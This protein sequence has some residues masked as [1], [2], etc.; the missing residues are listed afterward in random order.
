MD[1]PQS[2]MPNPGRTLRPRVK[3]GKRSPERDAELIA[4]ALDIQERDALAAGQLGYMART[5][6]WAS[7]PHSKVDGAYYKRENGLA[8]ITMLVDPDIGLPYGK[9][10][11]LITAWMTRQ[12]KLTSSPEL[13]LGR[14][15]NEFAQKLGLST[16]GGQRGDTSRLKAQAT[17]LLSTFISVN[18][19][20]RE[21]FAYK[22]VAVSDNGVLFWHPKKPDEPS[23]W[24]STITLS[25]AFYRDCIDCAVPFDLRVLHQLR[26]SLAID[27]YLWLTWR[28]YILHR[29]TLIPWA[30][31]RAQ[32]GAGYAATS[33]GL[34]HFRTA[35][36][37]CLADVCAVYPAARISPEAEGLRLRPSPPHVKAVGRAR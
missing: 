10:P 15:L 2:N 17:R 20:R 36:Y 29:P 6:I 11:R 4:T 23:L 27:L 9:L 16:S 14:S 5:M 25:P 31:L 30:T 24:E 8:T 35:F 37:R 19:H 1:S 12:A 28:M 21:D 7:M 13:L 26:S 22:N 3:A 32:F 34:A 33:Q 18:T